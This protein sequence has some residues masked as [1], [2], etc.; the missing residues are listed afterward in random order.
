MGDFAQLHAR[1]LVESELSKV[2]VT[3][4][5][6]VMRRIAAAEEALRLLGACRYD[7]PRAV[8]M[9]QAILERLQVLARAWPLA[10]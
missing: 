10:A 3:D 4:P 5:E 9:H 1:L 8:W 2:D 6:A 7:F